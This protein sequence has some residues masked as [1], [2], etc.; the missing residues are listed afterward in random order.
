MLRNCRAE[1]TPSF[2]HPVQVKQHNSDVIFIADF[3]PAEKEH[4]KKVHQCRSMNVHAPDA[5]I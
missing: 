2:F 5:S 3:A 4:S 1:L